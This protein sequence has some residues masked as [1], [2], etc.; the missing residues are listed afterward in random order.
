MQTVM[1]PPMVGTRR[2]AIMVSDCTETLLKEFR[3]TIFKTT[4]RFFC[5]LM[6]AQW[7]AGVAT[8]IWITPH[9]WI[10]TEYQ[11]HVHVFAAVFLGGAIVSLPMWPAKACCW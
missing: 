2:V 11:I 7:M 10:G 4:D 8:A 3:Q 6:L 1:Q 9:T 5:L